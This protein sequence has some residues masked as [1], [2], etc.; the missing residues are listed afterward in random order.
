MSDV[1]QI[2]LAVSAIDAP[3]QPFYDPAA[4]AALFEALETT[5]RQTESRKLLRLPL[6]IN[7][8]QFADALVEQFRAIATD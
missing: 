2:S 1:S 6:H 5:L 8:P 7:D 4:D 3:G